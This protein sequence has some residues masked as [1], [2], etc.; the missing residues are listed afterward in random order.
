MP[1]ELE[2]DIGA[3]DDPQY[4]PMHD[5]RNIDVGAWAEQWYS[6]LAQADRDSE[7][8]RQTESTLAAQMGAHPAMREVDAQDMNLGME[9]LRIAYSDNPHDPNPAYPIESYMHDQWEGV[10]A[11]GAIT[12]RLF[13]RSTLVD[14]ERYAAFRIEQA[15]AGRDFLTGVTNRRGLVRILHDRYGITDDPMRR[16]ESGEPLPPVDIACVYCDANRFKWINNVLGHDVGD[17]AITETA[18]IVEDM[19]RRSEAAIIYRHGGD[20]F[21]VIIEGLDD[22]EADGLARR[23][24]NEQI[25]KAMSDEYRQ[26]MDAIKT[27]IRSVKESGGRLRV[28][29]RP[30]ILSAIKG[31][32]ERR[33]RH[34]LYINGAAVAELSHIITLSLGAKTAPISNLNDIEE[35]RRASEDAM[36]GAKRVFHG[37]LERAHYLDESD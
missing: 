36:L 1:Y 12:G 18:C 5:Y 14:A 17:A 4:R 30:E 33:P 25:H 32:G 15:R 35:L 11:L 26:A 23:I 6:G 31:R 27:T 16:S 13:V 24:V 10:R 20:E 3:A 19:F 37:V 2:P 28:E 22:A 34:K 21:G 8:Y 9:L 29:A 7:F